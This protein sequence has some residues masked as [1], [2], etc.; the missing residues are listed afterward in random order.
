MI[1]KMWGSVLLPVLPNT[2]MKLLGEVLWRFGLVC[3]Q[4][5]DDTQPSFSYSI[6]PR[7]IL[8]LGVV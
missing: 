7:G 8:C 4:Y 6:E 3:H 2:Y 5:W 1:F